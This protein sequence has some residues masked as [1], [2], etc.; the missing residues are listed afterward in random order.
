MT[1]PA[2][3]PQNNP[4]EAQ[5][6]LPILSAFVEALRQEGFPTGAEYILRLETIVQGVLRQAPQLQPL[7]QPQSPSQPVGG[8]TVAPLSEETRT[9]LRAML[10]A[11]FVYQPER[12]S[13]FYQLFDLY[14]PS[15]LQPGSPPLA[16]PPPEPPAPEENTPEP[17]YRNRRVALFVA[18]LALLLLL[19]AGSTYTVRYLRTPPA[20]SPSPSAS[21]SPSPSPTPTP[22]ARERTVTITINRSPERFEPVTV[23]TLDRTQVQRLRTQLAALCA[24]VPLLVLLLF[25]WLRQ[26]RRNALAPPGPPFDQPLRLPLAEKDHDPSTSPEEYTL[27]EIFRSYEPDTAVA[28]Q[29]RTFYQG[30]R[31]L[32]TSETV[33]E[34]SRNR[35]DARHTVERSLN[36]RFPMPVFPLKQA[37]RRF[38]LLLEFRDARDHAITLAATLAEVLERYNADLTVYVLWSGKNACQQMERRQRSFVLKEGEPSRPLADILNAPPD[39]ACLVLFGAGYGFLGRHPAPN[40]RPEDG[41]N[42]ELIERVDRWRAAALLTPIAPAFWGWPEAALARHL[43]LFPVTY[44]GLTDFLKRTG[45]ID[46]NDLPLDP[47]TEDLSTARDRAYSSGYAVP[48]AV[49]PPDFTLL[50]DD[51][52]R[53]E[54]RDMERAAAITR[55]LRAYLGDDLFYWVCACAYLP[56]IR[57]DLTLYLGSKLEK[58]GRLRSHAL[59]TEENMLRLLELPWFRESGSGSAG[60]LPTDFRILLTDKR[61]GISDPVIRQTVLNAARHIMAKQPSSLDSWAGVEHSREA[62]ILEERS[63]KQTEFRTRV[64]ALQER[65][66]IEPLASHPLFRV[67]HYQDPVV[68]EPEFGPSLPPSLPHR[69]G[70]R[71][72]HFFYPA[73][74][75]FLGLRPLPRT[76]ATV[77]A[78]LV[79][80]GLAWFLIGNLY[81]PQRD[82]QMQ[83]TIPGTPQITYDPA[84][85]EGNGLADFGEMA[86][87]DEGTLRVVVD[88]QLEQPVSLGAGSETFLEGGGSAMLGFGDALSARRLDQGRTEIPLKFRV[89][90]PAQGV[91]A[92]PK[93]EPFARQVSLPLQTAGS[94]RPEDL[95]AR[96]D[97]R[98]V[99]VPM[100]EALEIGPNPIDFAARRSRNPLTVTLTN[101]SPG[102]AAA[103]PITVTKVRIEPQEAGNGYELD[104]LLLT[105]LVEPET[106][107]LAPGKPFTFSLRQRTATA[108]PATLVLLT[109]EGNEFRAR[110]VPYSTTPTLRANTDRL[111]YGELYYGERATYAL[112]LTA[113]GGDIEIAS[114]AFYFGKQR[115]RPLRPAS[116]VALPSQ[117]ITEGSTLTLAIP[118]PQVPASSV[119]VENDQLPSPELSILYNGGRELR[120]PASVIFRGLKVEPEQIILS[121]KNGTRSIRVT[122]AAGF[123]LTLPSSYW[124]SRIVNQNMVANAT[125]GSSNTSVRYS[126]ATATIQVNFS[127]IEFPYSSYT[128]QFIQVKQSVPILDGL[129]FLTAE[130]RIVTGTIR[131]E[132]TNLAAW[133]VRPDGEA[134]IEIAAQ[135]NK[136]SLSALDEERVS[137]LARRLSITIGAP[138]T[139]SISSEKLQIERAPG[140]LL[141]ITLPPA[142]AAA[143]VRRALE[144]ATPIRGALNV[145]QDGTLPPEMLEFPWSASGNE[146]V[147][148]TPSAF[149]LPSLNYPH[150]ITQTITISGWEG[151]RI[152]PAQI[153]DASKE[154]PLKRNI[155]ITPRTVQLAAPPGAPSQPGRI[156]K[157]TATLRITYTPPATGLELPLLRFPVTGSSK[158]LDIRFTAPTDKKQSEVNLQKPITRY[159][160]AYLLHY[161]FGPSGTASGPTPQRSAT[162]LFPDPDASVPNKGKGSAFPDVPSTSPYVDAVEWCQT[163]GLITGYSDGTFGGRRTVT[164]YEATLIFVKLMNVLKLGPSSFTSPRPPVFADVPAD[165]WAYTAVNTLRAMGVITGNPDGTFG[166][167]GLMTVD[168]ALKWTET[169]LELSIPNF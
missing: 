29:Q 41:L 90:P 27:L 58:S 147:T 60:I 52:R 44:D 50:V 71:T 69:W 62:A 10:A 17:P 45:I 35:L 98:L 56:E 105:R 134:V 70:R 34:G 119:E 4:Q 92:A 85:K 101:R 55:H 150:R 99:R 160:L 93:G 126:R 67:D 141:S 2:A 36:A 72:M 100:R 6:L 61:H 164:R 42:R 89:P 63:G 77:L 132:D 97:L 86:S 74:L 127:S 158:P 136:S 108:R 163:S 102:R 11:V 13:T 154:G 68:P 43:A 107:P 144:T 129:R 166:G 73:G 133:W 122:G 21:P 81:R 9:R 149:K 37:R 1:V 18:G 46:V 138:N 66:G 76:L 153:L 110:I 145:A 109:S 80:A 140:G 103:H 113:Q 31:R 83:R 112:K 162:T 57:W 14:F 155:V 169:V 111:N 148:A 125:V 116:P 96:V 15:A 22:A 88:N 39:D 167:N 30:K 142:Q 32:E 82:S 26:R 7:S 159:E 118:V 16:L 79:L 38:V 53:T 20:P 94:S 49:P 114:A 131:I 146:A 156:R 124:S 168:Q 65:V 135:T 115:N 152:G 91:G 5:A 104:E 47:S 78:S 151:Q 12:Q 8:E 143:F 106:S 157:G 165:H 120:L 84:N 40:E 48:G 64:R 87:G 33:Q 25:F 137:Q 23:R 161:A 28:D 19:F 121:P 139:V 54:T 24:A 123:A 128:D 117:R 51:E 75:S 95:T 3:P 59:V 130:V